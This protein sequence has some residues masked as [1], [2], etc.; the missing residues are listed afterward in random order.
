MVRVELEELARRAA[1]EVFESE[2]VAVRWLVEPCVSLGN[3][4][5]NSLLCDEGG[6]SLVL[7]ELR[8]IEHGLP[9]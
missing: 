8:A 9:I 1:T 6:L 2:S 3:V 4:P 7:R 5:P